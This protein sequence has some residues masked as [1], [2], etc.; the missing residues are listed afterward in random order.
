MKKDY[1][2]LIALALGMSCM[3]FTG[4]GSIADFTVGIVQL[5]DHVALDAANKGFREELEALL[6]EEGKT[7]KFFEQ[8]RFGQI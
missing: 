4:C 5:V 8:I 1:N 6:K 7:V 3:A 2:L